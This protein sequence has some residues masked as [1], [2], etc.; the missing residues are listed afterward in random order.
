MDAL[1]SVESEASAQVLAIIAFEAIL[2]K[3]KTNNCNTR[4][5]TLRLDRISGNSLWECPHL[6]EDTATSW[7]GSP[8]R[9]LASL[10]LLLLGKVEEETLAVEAFDE[11]DAIQNSCRVF[12]FH[13]WYP[14]LTD[15]I[16]HDRWML[17]WI[18]SAQTLHKALFQ[19]C[20]V[21]TVVF[22]DRSQAEEQCPMKRIGSVH[23]DS[24]TWSE[25]G[26]SH[27]NPD[28]QHELVLQW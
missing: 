22:L 12:D 15:W 19:I 26:W 21:I 27:V 28:K 13:Y 8:R 14:V 10:H 16:P 7:I 6:H 11:R 4:P 17:V 3:W 1:S 5:A 18:F 24:W 9:R 25:L 23:V 2:Y 20:N